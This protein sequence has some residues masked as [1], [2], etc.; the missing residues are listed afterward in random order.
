MTTQDLANVIATESGLTNLQ[1][2]K[3]LSAL[4]A[5]ISNALAN[6]EEVY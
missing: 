2:D 4:A 1:A 3:A 6:N 5:N